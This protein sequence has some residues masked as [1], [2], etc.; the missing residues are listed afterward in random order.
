MHSWGSCFVPVPKLFL[1]E[2]AL[3]REKVDVFI[4]FSVYSVISAVNLSFF[5][6]LVR[7]CWLYINEIRELEENIN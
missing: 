1:Y 3:T 4:F 6:V 7:A 5:F 2:S